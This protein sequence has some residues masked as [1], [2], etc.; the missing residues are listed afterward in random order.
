[1][2]GQLSGLFFDIWSNIFLVLFLATQQAPS[3][4]IY[5]GISQAIRDSNKICMSK[6]IFSDNR[7]ETIVTAE[8]LVLREIPL[9]HGPTMVILSSSLVILELIRRTFLKTAFFPPKPGVSIG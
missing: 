7:A 5:S 8:K 9:T 2:S 3:T 4:P 1:M 6:N